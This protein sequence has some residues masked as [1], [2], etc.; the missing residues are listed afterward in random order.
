MQKFFTTLLFIAITSIAIA[1]SKKVTHEVVKGETMYSISKKYHVTIESIQSA[2]KSL[3]PKLKIGEKLVIPGGS[4]SVATNKTEKKTTTSTKT[5][6]TTGPKPQAKSASIVNKPSSVS[7][8]SS[9][10]IVVKGETLYSIAKANGLK[11]MQLKDANHLA[12]DMK[13]KPGQKLIIPTKNQEAMYV[14]VSKEPISGPK[15]VV[16]SKPAPA[17]TTEQG[18]DYMNSQPSAVA[19]KEPVHKETIPPIKAVETKPEP[20]PVK[21]EVAKDANGDENPF[22]KP[23]G[24]SKPTPVEVSKPTSSNPIKNE[25]VDPNGYASVFNQYSESGKKKVVYRGIGMFMQSDNPGNQYLALYNYADMGSI[26]KI[27]NLMSKEA[28]YVKVIGKVAASDSEKDV[29]LKVS[30]DA[31]KMLKVNEDKFLVEVT[32]Y[33]AQ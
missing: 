7:A 32:G 33:N 17:N 24:A 16:V 29:I 27:T 22:A 10:H 1:Q 2:N 13:I 11:A 14:P 18:R 20:I 15:P 19:K 6:K 30:S 12:E 26:L 23:A 4:V 8:N 9:T 3:G 31:A 25:N 28:I 21:K 5:V